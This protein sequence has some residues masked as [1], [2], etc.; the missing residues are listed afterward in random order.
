MSVTRRTVDAGSVTIGVID[1]DLDVI[2][3]SLLDLGAAIHGVEVPD[4]DGQLGPV[5]LSLPSIADYAYVPLN[6]HLGA[7]LGRY[8]NRISGGAFTLDG[9]TYRLDTNQPPNTL[10]GGLRGFDRLTWSVDAI[11]ESADGVAVTFSLMSPDG[12]EGFPGALTALATYRISHGRI[13]ID[14]SATTDAP[15]VVSLANHGYWNLD[16]SRSIADHEL[17]VSA[18]RRLSMDATGIPTG[19]VEVTGTPYDLLTPQRLGPVIEATDGLDDCYLVDG[20]GLRTAA[21]LSAP[22]SGRTM[23]VSSDAPGLQ[24]YTGNSLH[25]PFD[26]HQSVSL[27]AQRLPDAPNQPDLGACMLRPGAEYRTVTRLDF[28]TDS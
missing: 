7:T 12:D 16:G 20:E 26:V 3:V 17:Q 15:T 27:E 2:R 18:H 6:P 19:V 1:I 9:T 24:V 21:R 14:M 5:H 4:R 8:A 23:T 25:P 22:H 13:E 11:D 28:G 10:H